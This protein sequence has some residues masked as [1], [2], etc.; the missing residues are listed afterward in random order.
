MRTAIIISVL[1]FFVKI[2]GQELPNDYLKARAHMLHERYDSALIYLNSSID[3]KQAYT[4]ARIQRGHCYFNLKQYNE[5]ISEFLI[6]NS[7]RTG[8]GSLMLAKSEAKLNH[9][10]LA[11]KYLREHLTTSNKIPEKDILLDEDF[12]KL[13]K[14]EAWKSLWKEKDWYNAYERELQEAVYLKSNG[15]N[16]EAINLLNELNK[17]GFK[18]SLVNQTLAEIYLTSGN[19]KAALEAIHI[20][21]NSDSRNIEALKFR[22]DMLNSSEEYE[23][24]RDDCNRLLRLAPSEFEYYLKAGKIESKLGEYESALKKVKFYLELFPLSSIAHNELGKI[25]Y[26]NLD[27]ISRT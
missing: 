25:H 16:L 3:K 19:E 9:E 27:C 20:S 13:A 23:E 8:R 4:E 6:V 22:I 11:V 10:E 18:R 26:E 21:V 15:D 24:A 14:S 7:Q 1:F 2:Q 17:K 12:D 5:A